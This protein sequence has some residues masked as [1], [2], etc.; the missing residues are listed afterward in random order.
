MPR[1]VCLVRCPSII[2]ATSQG[3][4]RV[5]KGWVG[6]GRL[7]VARIIV[8]CVVIALALLGLLMRDRLARLVSFG[9]TMPLR[10]VKA[11]PMELAPDPILYDRFISFV[12]IGGF[13]AGGVLLLAT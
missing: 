5:D 1:H 12:I 2:P 10:M 3:A 6:Y 9:R 13:F 11:Q 7:V 4:Q 8:G